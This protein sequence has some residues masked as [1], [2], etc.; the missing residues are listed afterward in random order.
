MSYAPVLN[1]P[2]DGFK[3]SCVCWAQLAQQPSQPI[4]SYIVVV[5]TCNGSKWKKNVAKLSNKLMGKVWILK[6]SVANGCILYI[7]GEY[8]TIERNIR[9]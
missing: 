4:N 7:R 2:G 6:L 9:S 3:L 8:L 5:E 1:L